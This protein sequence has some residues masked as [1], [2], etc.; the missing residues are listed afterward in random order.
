MTDIFHAH[1]HA[2]ENMHTDVLFIHYK[3]KNCLWILQIACMY[4]ANSFNILTVSNKNKE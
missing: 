2:M 1:L 4:I 3:M